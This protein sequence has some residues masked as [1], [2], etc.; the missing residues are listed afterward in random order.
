M[1]S[2]S[3]LGYENTR[4]VY[5]TE[6]SPSPCNFYSGVNDITWRKLKC[7]ISFVCKTGLESIKMKWRVHSVLNALHVISSIQNERSESGGL[8][9]I[10]SFGNAIGKNRSRLSGASVVFHIEITRT[11]IFLHKAIKTEK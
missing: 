8:W 7:L 4:L 1:K 6:I 2:L 3:H 10:H 11:K 5:K 9:W